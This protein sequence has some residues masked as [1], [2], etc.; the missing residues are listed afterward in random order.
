MS[1]SEPLSPPIR[2]LTNSTAQS[3]V[4]ARVLPLRKCEAQR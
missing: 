2:G 3:A 4:V 1:W